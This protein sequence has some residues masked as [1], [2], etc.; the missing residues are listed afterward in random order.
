MQIPK[1]WQTQSK[2]VARSVLKP[3]QKHEPSLGE[4]LLCRHLDALKIEY[5]QEFKFHPERKWKADFR[6]EGYPILVEVE[7]GVLSGGRHTRGKGYSADCEKY[8]AAA[9]LGWVVIRG[10][11]EQV[12]KGIV[13]GWIEEA[14]K[15]LKV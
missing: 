9:I 2:P 1:G 4:R 8:S 11:T 13:V 12:K 14:I 3:R 15:K 5:V 10:T 6:I 7:G